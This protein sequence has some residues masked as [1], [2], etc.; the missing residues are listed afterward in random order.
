VNAGSYAV[1]GVTVIDA[2]KNVSTTGFGNFASL[3]IG[4]TQVIDAARNIVNIVAIST[5][6][7]LTVG[8][9]GSQGVNAGSYAIGGTEV[10]TVNRD[11][12]NLRNA[13]VAGAGNSLGFYG[14]TAQPKQTITGSRSNPEQGL[15]NLL[16]ALSL[17]GLVTDS[18]T[19]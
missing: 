5:T 8:T 19:P 13:T 18:T 15:K 10:I 11:L 14:A 2:T 16:S 7:G 12:G 1:G 9:G 17:L 3:Q 6:G 4:G